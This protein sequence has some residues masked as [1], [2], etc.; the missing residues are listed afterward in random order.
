M[1]LTVFDHEPSADAG[2]AGCGSVGPSEI[3]G[4]GHDGLRLTMVPLADLRCGPTARIGGIKPSHLAELVALAGSWPPIVVQERDLIIV[5]GHYRYLAATQRGDQD[6]KCLLINSHGTDGFVEAI[7]RNTHH[8]LALNLQERKR[9]ATILMHDHP[10]WSDRRIADVCAL[11]PK[12]VGQVRSAAPRPG[13][14]QKHLDRRLG[15]NGKAH[16]SDPSELRLRIL[17][18]LDKDPGQSL[19]S[20][21]R[22]VGCS[23]ETVRNLRVLTDNTSQSNAFPGRR[24]KGVALRSTAGSIPWAEDSAMAGN[25]KTTA[26]AAWFDRTAIDGE[27]LQYVNDIPINRIYDI[28]DDARRR[29]EQW[30]KFATTLENRIRIRDALAECP[31]E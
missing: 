2:S 18:A 25:A 10:D 1:D 27:W 28:A 12:T 24:D 23:P 8:G 21:A 29:A 26:F 20:I 22:S 31:K 15:R 19:R 16:P 9:A 7:R 3:V 5:D 17:A 11:A 6:I 14:C 4:G 13:D 30:Q